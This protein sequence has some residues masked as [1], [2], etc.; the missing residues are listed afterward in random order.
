MREIAAAAIVRIDHGLPSM[1]DVKVP[2][3]IQQRHQLETTVVIDR[4]D[5]TI[6]Y[7]TVAFTD[8]DEVLLLPESIESVIVARGGLQSSRRTQI[9][10]NYR[11]FVG[12]ARIV[13]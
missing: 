4:E 1:L 7:R 10:S 13:E 3:K 8:P 6:R 9:Y 11:R 12:D 2:S 5:T